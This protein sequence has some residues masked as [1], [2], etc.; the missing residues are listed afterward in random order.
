MGKTAAVILAAGRGTRMR[1]GIAKALHDVGG[2][3]LVSHV[4]RAVVGAGLATPWVVTGFQADRVEEAL[5]G[6]AYFVRQPQMRG[7]GDA[8]FQALGELPDEVDDALVLVGDCPLI[9]QELLVALLEQHQASGADATIVT[10]MMDDATGYGRILR[11]PDGHVAGIV[12]E[13]ETDDETRAIQEI[14]TGLGIWR[15]AGLRHHLA[16]L[17]MHGDEQYLTDVVALLRDQGKRVEAFVYPDHRRVMGINTRRELSRAESLLRDLTH[18][19]LWDAGVTLLDPATTYVDVDVEI[20]PDTVIH[21]MTVLRGSTKIGRECEIGPM[22][23]IVASRIADGVVIG[24]SVVEQS[25]LASKVRVGPFSH[26]RAGTYLDRDVKIGNF[27]ELKNT[28]VGIGTKAGHHAYLGDATIGGRVN[29]GAGTVIVNF[30]GQVKHQ[31]FIGDEAFIG[32]NANL[33]AP[34]EIGAGSYVAAGSTIT[35]NVPSDGLGIARSR[36]D[37]KVGWA[38]NRHKRG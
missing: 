35:Q 20:G 37:N 10:T 18:Q 27:V 23:T 2:I 1:S 21:P 28:R 9:P 11:D 17:P 14:N 13:R 30:D 32:C 38:K 3:P 22:A 8:V 15:I 26:L 36:Q 5:D 25:V 16:D 29:I 19:R 12:E 4:I 24:Q 34:V 7:T 33:V 6:M 31:T